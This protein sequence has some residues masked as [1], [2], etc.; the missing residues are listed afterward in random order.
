MNG[1]Q[2][3]N[4]L[5][6]N[7][8]VTDIENLINKVKGIMSSKLITNQAGEI[9]EVHILSDLSR[10][11]KQIVRDVQSSVSAVYGIQLD[12]RLISIAQIDNRLAN[13]TEFRLQFTNLQVFAEGSKLAVKVFL[14]HSGNDYEG[15]ASG[16]NSRTNRSRIVVQA[17]LAAVH[18]FLSED[19]VFSPVDIQKLRIAGR[20]SY[21][22]TV[23]YINKQGEELL[24]GSSLVKHD[25]Y[26]AIARAT[27]DAVN[28]IITRLRRQ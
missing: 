15:C 5:K 11:A 25:E 4:L 9:I 13:E 8:E 2:R 10:G 3:L 7:V 27:L 23:G 18:T 28:R 1:E 26:D 19:Y 16:I 17:T 22:V 24:I 12:H 20:D 21:I 14:S 6:I